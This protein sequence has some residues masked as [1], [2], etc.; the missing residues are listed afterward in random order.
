MEE[1]GSIQAAGR[2]VLAVEAAAVADLQARIG[3]DFERAARILLGCAGRV[4]VTGMGKSG[5]VARKIAATL[6]ST[7]TPALFLHPAEAL[8]G[9]LGMLVRGDVV[10]ALSQSGETREL[11]ELLGPIKR[12]GIATIALTGAG[13]SLL[14][15]SAEVHLDVGVSAEACPL[16]LA[17]TAST[18][19]ALAMGDALALAVAEERGFSPRDFA[20]LHPGGTL[21]KRLTPVAELMHQGE[22]LPRVGPETAFAEVVYEMSRKG[23]GVTA[24]VGAGDR[25]LGLISDGDLRRLFQ[26]HGAGAVELAAAAYMTREPVTIA[27]EE[28][29]PAALLLME[30]RKI[31]SL[32]VADRERRLLGLLHLHDLWTTELI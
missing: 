24:V 13:G 17:P 6:S 7:G 18:T 9:D 20:D 22:A 15:R 21:G 14:A 25:L 19:A 27:P 16:G 4:V 11:L 26:A 12:L 3:A 28:L 10:V 31:T 32:L 2:R 23:L 30:Q 1:S 29:A 5:I 8:H